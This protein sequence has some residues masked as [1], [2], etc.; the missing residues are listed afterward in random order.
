MQI[1]MEFLLEYFQARLVE[2]AGGE[3]RELDEVSAYRGTLM[4]GIG[5]KQ[6]GPF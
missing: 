6:E 4:E 1:F 2:A 5:L 3:Q